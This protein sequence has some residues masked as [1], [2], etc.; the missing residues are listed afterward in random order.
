VDLPTLWYPPGLAI[1]TA[2][3][4]AAWLHLLLVPKALRR[5]IRRGRGGCIFGG[6]DRAGLASDARC[7]E[8]GGPLAAT[9]GGTVVRSKAGDR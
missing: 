5:N 8:C 1:D 2:L 9:K 6:Y 3:F 4:A 7:P